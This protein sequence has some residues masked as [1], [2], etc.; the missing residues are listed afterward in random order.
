MDF[1]LNSGALKEVPI[2][3]KYQKTINSEDTFGVIDFLK[4]SGSQSG[5][6]LSKDVL[7]VRKNITILPVWLFLLIV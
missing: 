2:E 1:V 4:V 3:V 6:I 5:L 7:E